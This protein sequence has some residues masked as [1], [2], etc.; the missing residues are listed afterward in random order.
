LYE[1][2][3]W[4]NFGVG[5]PPSPKPWRLLR[6]GHH[7]AVDKRPIRLRGVASGLLDGTEWRLFNNIIISRK[8][9]IIMIIAVFSQRFSRTPPEMAIIERMPGAGWS[10]WCRTVFRRSWSGTFSP[11]HQL[12]SGSQLVCWAL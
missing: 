7:T 9:I 11:R 1:N 2:A 3:T 5:N 8:F 6:T 10:L 12:I 4:D